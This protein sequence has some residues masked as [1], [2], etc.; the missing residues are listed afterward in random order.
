MM[1]NT[2]LF[3]KGLSSF[4]NVVFVSIFFLPF[5]FI[6]I[7]FL[8]KKFIFIFLFLLYKLILI[9]FLENK[10]IGMILIGSYWK[11]NYP[12]K[13]QFIHAVFYTISFSTLL[14]WIYFPF[15]LFLF[16]MLFIQIPMILYKGTTMHGYLAG[17]MVTVKKPNNENKNTKAYSI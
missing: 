10:S 13:N 4:I 11:E 6:D 15:D 8:I 3:E 14:F 7:P 2:T 12:L 9:Y 16:N 1:R 5:L 17:K